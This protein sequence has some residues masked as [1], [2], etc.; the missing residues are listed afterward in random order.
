[1]YM[2]VFSVVF[3]CDVIKSSLNSAQY[4]FLFCKSVQHVSLMPN[5][6]VSHPREPVICSCL[7]HFQFLASFCF[8]TY[9][10]S[11]VMHIKRQRKKVCIIKFPYNVQM[12][13]VEGNFRNK[14]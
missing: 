11:F 12:F 1:M 3:H 7:V 8:V 14:I 5:N 2:D 4:H 9:G 10:Y 6:M 13:S